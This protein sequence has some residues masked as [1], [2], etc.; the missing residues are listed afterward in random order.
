MR[1][2]TDDQARPGAG[3]AQRRVVAQL[4][5]Q[6]DVV[7]AADHAHRY[8]YPR[9][10]R[11][12]AQLPVRIAGFAVPQPLL[13]EP[14]LPAGQQTVHFGQ[15]QVGERPA[16]PALRPA[17]LVRER[18][19]RTALVA[20]D[21]DP[22]E[23]GVQRVRPAGVGR[24][25]ER[26]RGDR[27]QH[28]LERRP[29]VGRDGPLG[30]PDVARPVGEQVAVEPGLPLDPGDRVE[31]VVA[32]VAHRVELAAG[33]EGAPAALQDDVEAALGQQPPGHQP[34]DA[35]PA[36]RSADQ[37]RRRRTQPRLPVVGAQDGTVTRGDSDP[38][39]DPH[40]PGDRRRQAQPSGE[41]PAGQA[42]VDQR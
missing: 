28:A 34:D 33:V 25:A 8:R 7:P 20:D 2:G 26:R 22:V 11:V 37:H 17:L 5:R 42:H 18:Q 40:R 32:L 39:A 10:V 16:Q 27:G 36:V 21:G 31:A 15:W 1:P 23:D 12:A 13:E 24:V 29:R 41:Y 38:T 30:V 9:H 3:G 35:G 14:D 6:E 19:Q 4:P